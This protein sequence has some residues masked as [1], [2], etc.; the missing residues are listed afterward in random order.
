MLINS[1]NVRSRNGL[2]HVPNGPVYISTAK[3]KLRVAMPR[4]KPVR[5]PFAQRANKYLLVGAAQEEP[6]ITGPTAAKLFVESSM[7]DAD[8][9]VTL[10][11]FVPND[12]EILFRSR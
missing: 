8:I 5:R 6:E 4:S 3:P 7:T 1:S 2:S 10:R 11:A 12:C 9:F